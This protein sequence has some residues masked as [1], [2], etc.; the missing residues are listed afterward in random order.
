MALLPAVTVSLL[1]NFT[2]VIVALLSIVLLAERPTRWQ[3][4]GVG[5]AAL[6]AV[7]YFYPVALPASQAIGLLVVL[8]GVFA[9]ALSSILGR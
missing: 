1:L 2:T 5:V 8:G 9:N 3:W 4:L 7:I 6:G